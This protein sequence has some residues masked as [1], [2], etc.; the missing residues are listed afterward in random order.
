MLISNS[1]FSRLR[2]G[3]APCLPPQSS[4]SEHRCNLTVEDTRDPTGHFRSVGGAAWSSRGD[5]KA[6]QERTLFEVLGMSAMVAQW[7]RGASVSHSAFPAPS[8][9]EHRTG[10]W[11][12]HARR[13]PADLRAEGVHFIMGAKQHTSGG[14][15]AGETILLPLF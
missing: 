9:K 7:G 6:H 1:R 5:P 11:E 14:E 13:G 4:G 3:P 2:T 15:G 8:P 12:K 10:P